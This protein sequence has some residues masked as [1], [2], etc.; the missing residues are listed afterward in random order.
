MSA[1]QKT[2]KQ[3]LHDANE[4]IRKRN[5]ENT[6]LRRTIDRI[7]R[8]NDL[9]DD[10][11][12]KIFGLAAHTPDPPDWLTGKAGKPGSRGAPATIWSDWHWG[13]VVQEAEVGGVNSFDRTVARKRAQRLV[14][15]TIDLAFNHMGRAKAKYPGIIVALGGDMLGGDIHEELMVTNDCTTMETVNEVTDV[16]AGCL[17]HM[18]D[19]FKNVFVP[20][21]VG[22]HGRTTRKPRLKQHVTTNL[23]WVIYCNLE[24]EFRRD[25]RISF[26]VPRETD[27]HFDV[28]GHRYLLTHGDNLGVKGGDGIIGALGPIMRGS[29][30]T[31]RSEAQIGRAYDTLLIGH[32]HQYLTLPGL[33]TNNS[34]KGYDEFARLILRA[35]YSR[36]SQALWFTHPE[37]GITAH[38]Q[39]YLE[40]LRQANDT[41]E[42]VTFPKAK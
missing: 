6:D 14:N 19:K 35:P 40:P 10:I 21:V 36:P 24:R 33:I 34:F 30:K 18:A 3:E 15:T 11:R 37:H 5:I 17:A 23:D 26:M 13:E 25:P 27:A 41:V 16:L 42:W 4:M 22:N 12:T 2:V 29:I 8:E 20:C 32:W 7:Q 9:Q 1:A 31:G 28:F 38:W 39:V